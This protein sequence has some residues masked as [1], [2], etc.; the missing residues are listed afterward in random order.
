MLMEYDGLLPHDD[1]CRGMHV[2]LCP[3]ALGLYPGK[4]LNHRNWELVSVSNGLNVRKQDEA[5]AKWS[6]AAWLLTLE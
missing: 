2:P 1:V 6:Q 4:P 3:R 5:K